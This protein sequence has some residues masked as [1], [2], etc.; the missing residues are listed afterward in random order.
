ML[1]SVYFLF[2]SI[3]LADNYSNNSSIFYCNSLKCPTCPCTSD[4]SA[5]I[6]VRINTIYFYVIIWFLRPSLISTNLRMLLLVWISFFKFCPMLFSN[7]YISFLIN[8]SFTSVGAF[9]NRFSRFSSYFLIASFTF[10]VSFSDYMT[11][12]WSSTSSSV[13]KLSSQHSLW[14]TFPLIFI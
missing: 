8:F 10:W 9:S 6:N 14:L 11:S 12:S 1:C 7:S 2:I 13:L 3:I 4:A 5:S